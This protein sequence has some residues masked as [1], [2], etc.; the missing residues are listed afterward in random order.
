MT[1]TKWYEIAL[2]G[3]DVA[4]RAVGQARDFGKTIVDSGTTYTYL[5][6]VLYKALRAA[7]VEACGSRCG[8]L[9]SNCYVNA[10][11]A[12][13]PVIEVKAG[14]NIIQWLPRSYMY[15]DDSDACF[16]F[17]DNGRTE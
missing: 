13:F 6:P 10:R 4:G 5:P 16:G 12:N 7:V 3:F 2:D 8:K 15:K 14:G 1:L 17:A 9:L 11:L